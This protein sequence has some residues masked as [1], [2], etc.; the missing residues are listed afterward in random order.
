MLD[1]EESLMYYS[2]IPR[3]TTF[4]VSAEN[5]RGERNGGTHGKDCEKLCPSILIPAGGTSTICDLDGCGMITS[6]WFGGYHGHGFIVRMYWDDCR[7]PSVECPVSAFFGCA[8]D[9]RTDRDGK[10]LVLNSA[11]VL[12]SPN[13]GNNCYWEMPFRKHCRITIENRL[14]KDE[15]FFYMITGWYGALPEDAGYFH[16]TFRQEHPITRGKSYTALDHVSGHGFLAGIALAAGLNGA[17]SCWVEGEVKMYIDAEKYP[18]MNYTGTED[19][20]CGSYAFGNDQPPYQ[21]APFSGHYVGMYA[22]MGN[23]QERY[24]RQQRFLLYR[25][26]V[27]D[28]I[29]FNE[30]IRVTMDNLGGRDIPRYDDYATTAYYYLDHPSAVPFQLPPEIDMQ[31]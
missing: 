5:P 31:Y 19:Y 15:W 26:H 11:K 3:R 21:Y 22:I 13:R 23:L 14:E 20:F 2:C 6:L 1:E 30:S 17:N 10:P 16:A 24:N 9:D 28:P 25:W 7:E 8:Y 27:Q 29:Y 12:V 18:S 4:G